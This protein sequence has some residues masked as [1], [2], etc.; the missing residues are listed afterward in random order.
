MLLIH[1]DTTRFESDLAKWG[2]AIDDEAETKRL[3]EEF[4]NPMWEAS[5]W[6]IGCDAEE[7][8]EALDVDRTGE[9][10]NALS[11]ETQKHMEEAA[12]QAAMKSGA[13]QNE[14]YDHRGANLEPP[15]LL[16]ASIQNHYVRV[17]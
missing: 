17:L 3:M 10:T 12:K 6:G 11:P 15:N 13:G 1:F 4:W 5:Y 14:F 7:V 16:R 9:Q 8:M 2:V